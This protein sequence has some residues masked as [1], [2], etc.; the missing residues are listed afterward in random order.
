MDFENSL[1]Y[2]FTQLATAFRNNLHK[3]VN[4]IN[5]HSGQI[6][7]LICLWKSDGQ[8]QIDLANNLG[9]TPP[10]INKM[11]KGLVESGFVA[12]EK[13]ENDGRIMRVYLTDKGRHC[14]QSA[15]EIWQQYETES[16]SNL[17]DTEKLM[18][19]H[20]LEKLRENTNN[21][22]APESANL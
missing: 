20:L 1:T 4:A 7:L 22:I 14:K 17:T 13:G 2:Q 16:F 12:T 6:F 8:S 11:V 21:K 15:V 19:M 3:T 9:L 5:L 18:L 10:T